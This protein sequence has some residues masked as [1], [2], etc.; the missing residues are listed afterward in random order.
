MYLT[1]SIYF[2]LIEVK[3]SDHFRRQIVLDIGCGTGEATVELLDK[4]SIADITAVDVSAEFIELARNVNKYKQ[5]EFTQMN[6]ELPWPVNWEQKFTLVSNN[7]D[8]GVEFM[9]HRDSEI[10]VVPTSGFL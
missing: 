2:P 4:L 6:V 1:E 10:S 3:L 7:L 5:V 9:F 8:L